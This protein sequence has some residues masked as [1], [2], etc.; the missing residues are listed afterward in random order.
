LLPGS[1]HKRSMVHLKLFSY[2]LP[3]PPPPTVIPSLPIAPAT[4]VFIQR[5]FLHRGC[6]EIRPLEFNNEILLEMF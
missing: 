6:P 5:F 4:Y 3:T 1:T 2:F